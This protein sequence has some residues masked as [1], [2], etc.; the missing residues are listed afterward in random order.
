MGRLLFFVIALSIIVG[1]LAPSGTPSRMFRHRAAHVAPAAAPSVPQPA[2]SPP[3]SFS[4]G[5]LSIPRG[6]TGHFETEASINGQSLPFVVD[7]GADV[8]ALTV[9]DARKAGL[10][11]DPSAF[12]VVAMGAS[13]PVKGQEVTLDRLEV[14]GRTIEHVRGAVLEGLGQNLLGQSALAQLGGVEMKGDRMVLR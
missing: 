1:L 14:N 4:A 10:F 13:G 7:T 8:V 3:V 9:N 5:E 6:P 2:S 11:F 12:K